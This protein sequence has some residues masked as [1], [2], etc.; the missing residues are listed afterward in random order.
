M[1]GREQELLLFFRHLYGFP[2]RI[3]DGGDEGE[4]VDG[5]VLA[6][7]AGIIKSRPPSLLRHWI[8]GC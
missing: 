2:E 3:S 4:N 6:F 8:S 7:P 1:R 5:A